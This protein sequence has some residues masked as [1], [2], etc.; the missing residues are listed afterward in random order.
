[1][2]AVVRRLRYRA[3]KR[4]DNGVAMRYLERTTDYTRQQ[5]TRLVGRAADEER[6]YDGCFLT[7][8]KQATKSAANLSR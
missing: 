4:A 8:S 1:V 7:C 6:P 2:A 5:L 3:L